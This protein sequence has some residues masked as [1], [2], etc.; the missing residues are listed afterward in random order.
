MQRLRELGYVEG[1]NLTVERRWAEGRAERYHELAAELV[2]LKPDVI[3]VAFTPSVSAAK[4]ATSTIPIVMA[5]AGDPV[6]TGLVASL[7]RPGGNI[8][9][10]SQQNSPES[11]E[12]GWNYSRKRS[13][14]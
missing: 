2:A 10:M 13:R 6:G 7:A 8:T 3:V 14:G 4:R 11:Q 12:S 9:G 5:I 1:Q